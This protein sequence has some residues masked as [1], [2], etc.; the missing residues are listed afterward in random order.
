MKHS[1]NLVRLA[2]TFTLILIGLLTT[3]GASQQTEASAAHSSPFLSG[4]ATQGIEFEGSL[5]VGQNAD[6]RLEVFARGSD[7]ALWH[8]WQLTP[9]DRM[10]GWASL[11]GVL[12]GSPDVARDAS[13][14]L[15][16]FVKGTDNAIWLKWQLTPGSSDSWS[17]WHTLRGV[18]SVPR[19]ATNADGRL[20]IFVVGSD[21]GLWH[22]WQTQAGPSYGA[23][24][25]WAPLGGVIPGIFA[26][27]RNADGR[28]EVFVEGT[29]NG[30]W[31]KRQL[32]PGSSSWS[33]WASFGRFLD[34]SVARNADGRMEVFALGPNC[35]SWHRWQLTPGGS[36]SG[37]ESLGGNVC[38]GGTETVAMNADGRLEIFSGT[39]ERIGINHKWQLT[40]GG[41]W[42]NWE[43]LQGAEVH[44]PTVARNADGRLEIFA[45]VTGGGV[46]HS[47]QLTPGGAW[48]DW[49]TL[50]ESGWH[51]WTSIGAPP[52]PHTAFRPSAVGRATGELDVVAVSFNGDVWHK[53]WSASTGWSG[54]VSLGIPPAAP[55]LSTSYNPAIA[56]RPNGNLDVFV[57]DPSGNV[58][59]KWWS[60]STGWSGWESLGDPSG[61]D[62]NISLDGLAA[63]GRA[64][65]ELDVIATTIN[66]SDSNMPTTIWHKWWSASTGWSAWGS[67]GEIQRAHFPAAAGRKSG[68]LDVF[69]GA[70]DGAVWHKWWSATGG[71]HPWESLGNLGGPVFQPAAAGRADGS[72]DVVG[73]G[74]GGGPVYH[75]WWN[76]IA[77]WRPWKSLGAPTTGYFSYPSIAARSNGQIYVFVEDTSGNIYF[78]WWA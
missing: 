14:R 45:R 74:L 33:G 27:E 59:H 37:W 38:G 15:V 78:T 12:N 52:N 28:L 58:W 24:S 46:S 9:G 3:P 76:K 40:P 43:L 39:P 67:L 5:R 6:G 73:I 22:I 17:A 16:V 54:W 19:V 32:T 57:T 60:A 2:I 35:E 41:G 64:T 68:E 44:D 62:I 56:G 29:D 61:N 47:W 7:G 1:R 72:L 70:E 13:G 20:E 53:S 63:T 51:Q 65:G 55:E 71:W 69:V 23:W 34:P 21:N 66:Y 36:W 77:G 75:A 48:S 31:N 8:N 10:A 30:L 42:S 26:V 25:G 11:G 18:V 49:Y 4:V 50:G